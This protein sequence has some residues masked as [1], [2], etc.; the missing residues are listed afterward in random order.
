MPKTKK[1]TSTE[2]DGTTF[3]QP[4]PIMAAQ[5][6]MVPDGPQDNASHIDN[7]I[8][9]GSRILS[10]DSI[11]HRDISQDIEL[12]L[13][14]D[15]VGNPRP[16]V[17]HSPK[18]DLIDILDSQLKL[19]EAELIIQKKRLELERMR[20]GLNHSE[21]GQTSANQ[22]NWHSFSSQPLL[23][24]NMN[25]CGYS[26]PMNSNL[27]LPRIEIDPF[28]G[29]PEEFVG[30]MHTFNVTIANR[31]ADDSQKLAYLTYYCRGTAKEA[32]R[33]CSLLPPD[34]CYN[35]AIEILRTQFGMPHVVAH[36][37]TKDLYEGA[38]IRN[39]NTNDLQT[40]IR[41]M[42]TC[43]IT[44]SQLGREADLNC[45]SNLLKIAKR[46]TKPMQR[47]WAER[48]NDIRIGGQ[49]P[50]FDHLIQFVTRC[51]SIANTEYG[52]LAY[53]HLEPLANVKSKYRVATTYTTNRPFVCVL[54]KDN[55][56]LSECTLF[57]KLKVEDRW[58]TLREHKGC[59]VCFKPGHR[60]NECYAK[61]PCGKSGCDKFHHILLHSDTMS[62]TPPPPPSDHFCGVQGRCQR[63]V[64]LGFAPVVLSGPKGS[65]KTYAL[66]DNGSDCTLVD[67][68]VADKL[69]I[70]TECSYTTISTLHGTRA[71]PCGKGALSLASLDGDFRT[72]VEDVLIV[73][74]L[75]IEH[76]TKWNRLERWS[77]LSDLPLPSLSSDRVG[78]LL[79]CDVSEA[80]WPLDQRVSTNR[81]PFAIRSCLGWTI[82]GPNGSIANR[83]HNVNAIRAD[84]ISDLLTRLYNSEFM[85]I[86]D[87]E[88]LQD[89]IEDSQALS[90]VQSSTKYVEGR[91]ELGVPWNP[92]A[93]PLQDNK[94]LCEKRLESLR[95]RLQHNTL[96]KEKYIAVMDDH[97]SKGYISQIREKKN[98]WYLPHHPVFN[99]KK[100]EKI[101]VVFDCAAR[102]N[103]VSLN[104]TL[105]QGPDWTSKLV[106]VLLRFRR[107]PVA[108][109]A[110]IK[111]M[112]LQVGLSK[113]DRWA[114]SFLWWPTNDLED[115]PMV[116]EWNV[117][118]FGAKSSP[119]CANYALRRTVTEFAERNKC[120]FIDVVNRNFYV[121]DYLA[122][123]MSVE[124]ARSSI[125]E[126]RSLLLHGHFDLVKW[127]SNHD[128]VLE[129][130]PAS[131]CLFNQKDLSIADMSMRTLGL[132]WLI[133]ED[134]FT[135]NIVQPEG[136]HT[137]RSILAYVASIYDPLGLIAPVTLVGKQILQELCRTNQG[138][139]GPLPDSLQRAWLKWC[140]GLQ[141]LRC[142][143]IPRCIFQSVECMITNELHVFSDA[144]ERGYGV[145]GYL[146]CLEE[147]GNIRSH[148]IYGKARVAPLKAITVPR[149]ELVAALLAAKVSKQL[150][151]ELDIEVSRTCL[152][153]DSAIVLHY[154][155]N[156]STRYATFVANRTRRIQELTSC[157]QW[158]FIST[159]HNP[160]DVASRGIEANSLK[161]FT[162]LH[163]PDWLNEPEEKWSH[164]NEYAKVNEDSLELKRYVLTSKDAPQYSW[165]FQYANRCSSWLQLLRSIVWLTRF[166]SYMILKI[167]SSTET[168]LTLGTIKTKELEQ[169]T[170]DIVRMVQREC[171]T[172]DCSTMSD[173]TTIY[174]A[175]DLRRLRPVKVHGIM[176][177]KGRTSPCDKSQ[178]YILPYKGPITDLI[179]KHY[180]ET[181]GHM[182][183]TYVLAAVRRKFWVVK[184]MAAVRRI[185]NSCARCRVLRAPMCQQ[186]MGPLPTSRV[187][188]ATHPFRFCG[189]DYFGPF[190]VI[191]G[192]KQ[193]K[194]FGCLFTCMQTR[195]VHIEV[196]QELSTD[197]FLMA[198]M[199]FISR[200]GSPQTIHSDNGTNFVGAESELKEL[201]TSLDQKRISDGLHI[202]TIDWVFNPPYAS[203]RGGI[204]ERMIRTIRRILSFIVKEQP[205]SDEVLLTSL[206]EVERIINDRPLVPIYD[207][208]QQP[209]ALRPNDLLLLRPNQGLSNDEIPL[210]DRYTKGWRQA[211]HLANIFWKRWRAE[212]FPTLRLTQKWL[213]PQENLKSGDLVLIQ[214]P[215][216]P[217]GHWPKGIVESTF[218]GAD[219]KVRQVTVRT[220]QGLI[221][222]DVR[223]LCL[224][225][226]ALDQ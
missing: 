193:M 63:Q 52:Q 146:R 7:T 74:K 30:F 174:T 101:R 77:H 104:D 129:D 123:F 84:G 181:S 90:M 144:S 71:V 213:S 222:R 44:L 47:G 192:R 197:S 37:V 148:L 184:G 45:T 48:V 29:C 122:S 205:T 19:D 137:R 33:H 128:E 28:S 89:S 60:S 180:H 131:V 88:C 224:L 17:T 149:L 94:V 43:Q 211:Q 96:L 3:D 158:R 112:F 186:V 169:A 178:L 42:H 78:I 203:H 93:P 210:R 125:V 2:G 188:S 179:V 152:W 91:Y 20:R 160:A 76:A 132:L 12:N 185:L 31:I 195:A 53:D 164:S 207:D 57:R 18:Q 198:L 156:T 165:L 51:L 114:F 204:W 176:Y 100:P 79:G 56:G 95:R 49:E 109:T 54:C 11:P 216:T 10:H 62:T 68:Y 209:S 226:G 105:L 177:L 59:Y 214:R 187:K 215:S 206:A 107:Y 124:E 119:F 87:S 99:P 153:T 46:F 80:H 9:V 145:A 142:V 138:W 35:T 117:H 225:E 70:N 134:S 108:V 38:S 50:N 72:Q 189:I 221:K 126:L 150:V 67:K 103:D 166:R 86:H 23:T 98:R 65:M 143:Q 161:L 82:R 113:S 155:A 66:L 141:H 140:E 162:W 111:E 163:G 16:N 182:G 170:A 175:H 69:G 200:R 208:P 171:F 5:P 190:T 83:K 147:H 212:Y 92:N 201:I 73:R 24:N 4:C 220:T 167:R 135:F 85:D 21:L 32:I 13:C 154:I 81:E 115:P 199:R 218:P 41:H 64:Q 133:Q 159:S 202:H 25:V 196:A 223:S 6:G 14:D 157:S 8:S 136:P 55:H 130:L 183:S 58:K 168:S 127:V 36:K 40:L 75:P 118:P 15:N 191:S 116:Y 27:S 194:R 39:G 139:D 120:K 22:S 217:R 121:D 34:K 151:E 173:S 172:Q 110:D 1:I 102:F 219:S 61:R 97:L 26:P 106:G